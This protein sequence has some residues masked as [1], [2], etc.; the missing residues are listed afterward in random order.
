MLA[1]PATLPPGPVPASQAP[2]HGLGA[3]PAAVP[4]PGLGQP[5][6]LLVQ[7]PGLQDH[8]L[9]L[10]GGVAVQAAFLLGGRAQVQGSPAVPP[11]GPAPPLWPLRPAS[12]Q[13]Y[14]GHKTRLH[15]L[16]DEVLPQHMG[17]GGG[18]LHVLEAG[19]AVLGVHSEEL[20]G[21]HVRLGRPDAPQDPAQHPPR[22]ELSRPEARGWDVQG[23]RGQAGNPVSTGVQPGKGLGCE[24]SGPARSPRRQ[25]MVC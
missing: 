16:L 20:E 22:E 9:Q 1:A 6:L 13:A 2:T 11:H 23:F 12:L 21:V 15:I 18:R 14:I 4:G 3:V 17:Q 24:W 10:E 25:R 19:D 5:F 8:L 7:G